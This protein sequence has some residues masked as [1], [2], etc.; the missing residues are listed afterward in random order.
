MTEK[1]SKHT[2][3]KKEDVTPTLAVLQSILKQVGLTVED[4]LRE[5][6]EIEFNLEIPEFDIEEL[7]ADTKFT[8]N[9]PKVSKAPLPV[10]GKQSITIRID[11]RVLLTFREQA[12]KTGTPYQTLIN[13][14]LQ[15]AADTFK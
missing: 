15:D 9:P 14:A 5:Q 1:T 10:I 6:P 3:T 4:L 8:P 12:E 7:L 13:R 11:R 2:K